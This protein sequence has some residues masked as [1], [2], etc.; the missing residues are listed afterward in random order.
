M[1]EQ[2]QAQAAAEDSEGEAGPPTPVKIDKR[3]K[4]R[5][6]DSESDTDFQAQSEE[7]TE[8][9][10]E[11]EE[12]DMQRELAAPDQQRSTSGLAH[13]PLK[14]QDVNRGP[15]PGPAIARVPVQRSPVKLPHQGSS[16]MPP[17]SS[18][19][20]T[21]TIPTAKQKSSAPATVISLIPPPTPP[22]LTPKPAVK[23]FARANIPIR[24]PFEQPVHFQSNHVCPACRTSHPSGACELK[25][26]GVEHCGLCGLAHFGYSRTCPHI[27]SETQVREMLQA[28]KN[29][30]EKREL[31]DLAMKYL[32]GVKG[33]LV[34]QKKRD[35]EK[36][37]G[38][39]QS[40]TATNSAV[41]AATGAH[42]PGQSG[43]GTAALSAPA[44]RP[45]KPPQPNQHIEHGHR[46][47]GAPQQNG[48]GAHAQQVGR[49]AQPQTGHADARFDETRVEHAL[50]GFLGQD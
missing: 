23:P 26:A 1:T 34:Q 43:V 5:R 3:T 14:G 29:S 33:A 41:A 22:K 31:I 17:I 36:A 24:S 42:A 13:Q 16:G 2:E 32:R 50:K 11:A 25:A 21:V 40:M 15:N 35:R 6:S 28:L 38:L 9:E 45:A 37:A 27:K 44:P 49:P 8:P 48:H 30:P 12:N 7:D 19:K 18:T 46:P 10:I 47:P 20:S 39:R 4:K